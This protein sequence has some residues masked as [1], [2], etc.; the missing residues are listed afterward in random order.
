MSTKRV[1]I[2]DLHS[3]A[4]L[5]HSTSDGVIGKATNADSV[6]GE[7]Q[8]AVT[9]IRE[10]VK[11]LPED[12][13]GDGF[14]AI[15]ADYRSHFGESTTIE[16]DITVARAMLKVMNGATRVLITEAHKRGLIGAGKPCGTANHFASTLG[17]SPAY[18]SQVRSKI[19]GGAVDPSRAPKRTA[20]SVDA[21]TGEPVVPTLPGDL[22]AL[23]QALTRLDTATLKVVGTADNAEDL[24]RAANALRAM[25]ARLDNVAKVAP[26]TGTD[27]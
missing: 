16:R 20:P 24:R 23:Q 1:S 19:N 18:V 9:A 3:D 25:A 27:G 21:S 5:R 17:V 4:S 11:A 13:N 15:V 12:D 2:F 10:A 8:R 22:T 6:K 14:V 26:A 7:A